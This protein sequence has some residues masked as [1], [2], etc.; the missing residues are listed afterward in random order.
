MGQFEWQIRFIQ[1][2]SPV[3]PQKILLGMNLGTKWSPK[4]Y[5]AIPLS[6]FTQNHSIHAQKSTKNMFLELLY[7][8]SNNVNHSA[9]G[10]WWSTKVWFYKGPWTL[11]YH[12]RLNSRQPLGQNSRLP[13]D[14]TLVYHWT[15]VYMNSCLLFYWTFVYHFLYFM[16]DESS[17]E[18]SQIT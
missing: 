16:V 5:Q 3:H 18:V 17:V 7:P 6:Y 1:I 9:L 13:E 12:Q 15:L 10:R 8:S 4:W 11:V 2:W 14:R